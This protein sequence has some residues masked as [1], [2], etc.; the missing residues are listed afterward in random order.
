MIFHADRELLIVNL[1]RF[2]LISR[3]Y[4]FKF[5]VKMSKIKIEADLFG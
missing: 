1:G 3:I 2:A 4:K 5:I